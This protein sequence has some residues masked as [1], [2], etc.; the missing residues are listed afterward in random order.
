MSLT[1]SKSRSI[2]RLGAVI[3]AIAVV[4]AAIG[5]AGVLS[6]RHGIEQREVDARAHLTEEF[7]F[8]ALP[9]GFT[10]VKTQ[11]GGEVWRFPLDATQ[12]PFETRVFEIER[13][14]ENA[15]QKL[16]SG[17]R[18]QGF[19][20]ETFSGCW[21]VAVRKP[22]DLT[23]AFYPRAEENAAAKGNGCPDE[24][25]PRAFATLHLILLV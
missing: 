4:I 23:I 9:D 22:V 16:I 18:E 6:I 5:V 2:I 20:L 13:N 7:D 8:I 11:K 21:V 19:T 3:A 12:G 10:L 24:G 25:W 1:G 14:R 17:L 15:Y